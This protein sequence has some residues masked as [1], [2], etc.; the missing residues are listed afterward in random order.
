[1]KYKCFTY[2]CVDIPDVYLMLQDLRGTATPKT[3]YHLQIMVSAFLH[4]DALTKHSSMNMEKHVALLFN[5]IQKFD[6][7][8]I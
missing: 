6:R 7:F 8:K 3:T 2:I 1:M 4:F 5:L